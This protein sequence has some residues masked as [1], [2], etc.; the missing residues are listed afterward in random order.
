[1]LCPDVRGPDQQLANKVKDAFRAL[2][3][4]RGVD[5]EFG[6]RLPRL[7]RG[8][9]LCEVTADAYFPLARPEVAML[10][11]ANIHQ[12]RDSLVEA[13]HVTRSEV[14]TF[15]ALLDTGALDLATAPLISVAG[16]LSAP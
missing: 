6:R 4:A 1:M 7:L 3:F 13:G 11:R 5:P 9:G 2:L 12:V 14:E 10:E 8:L 16:A 15:L